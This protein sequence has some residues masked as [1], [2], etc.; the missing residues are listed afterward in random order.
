MGVEPGVGAGGGGCFGTL[1]GPEESGAGP[2]MVVNCGWGLRGLVGLLLFD[3]WI[4]DASIA[5]TV[6]PWVQLWLVGGCFCVGVCFCSV[7]LCSSDDGAPPRFLRGGV[8]LF[9]L[10]VCLA[11]CEGHMVDALASRAD[12]GRWSLR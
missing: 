11:S 4:V 5:R 1:L 7:C 6:G 3:S 10:S 9:L 12:E 8:L 2:A